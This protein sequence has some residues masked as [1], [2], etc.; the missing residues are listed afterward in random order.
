[1]KKMIVHTQTHRDTEKT[2]EMKKD[3]EEAQKL[4]ERE[5]LK[6]SFINSPFR[7]SICVRGKNHKSWV[8]DWGRDTRDMSPAISSGW[9][10]V[11]SNNLLRKLLTDLVPAFLNQYPQYYRRCVFLLTC[12]KLAHECGRAVKASNI[13]VWLYLPQSSSVHPGINNVR[14]ASHIDPVTVGYICDV[15]CQNIIILNSYHQI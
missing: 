14:R 5:I 4:K 11:P 12:D 15:L 6:V 3:K 10:I 1:M 9:K 2:L 13:L 7:N 8:S